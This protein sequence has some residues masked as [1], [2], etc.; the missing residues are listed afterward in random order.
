[1]SSEDLNPE[2]SNYAQACQPETNVVDQSLLEDLRKEQSS[3]T[4][5]FPIC[6]LLIDEALDRFFSN[7]LVPGCE[8]Y[9]DVLNHEPMKL[10]QKVFVPVKQYPELNLSSMFG[11]SLVQ[12]QEAT[13][14]EIQIKGRNSMIDKVKEEEL[15]QSGDPR[16]KHLNKDLFLEISTV[17]TPIECYTRIAYALGEIRKCLIPET[18]DD[19]SHEELS[20]IIKIEP[21]V[22]GTQQI[23]KC[24]ELEDSPIMDDLP[25]EVLFKEPKTPPPP[26]L[27]KPQDKPF[28]FGLAD[29]L[30]KLLDETV[31]NPNFQYSEEETMMVSNNIDILNSFIVS[32]VPSNST[33]SSSGA[34]LENKLLSTTAASSKVRSQSKN[35]GVTK[36]HTTK[37]KMN[38]DSNNV[39][40]KTD[41]TRPIKNIMIRNALMK[42]ERSP[43]LFYIKDK[44]ND[45]II[46]RL[47]SNRTTLSRCLKRSD[48]ETIEPE[49]EVEYNPLT[50]DSLQQTPT[51]LVFEYTPRDIILS[52]LET[53]KNYRVLWQFH[54]KPFN[55]DYIEA[56]EDLCQI[57]NVKWSLNIDSLKMR[58]SINRV[59][60]FYRFVFPYENIEKFSEYFDKCA[61]FLPSTV[62]EIPH[63]RCSHCFICF[64]ED[65]ELRRH[66]VEEHK[67]LKWPHKCQ[68][69]AESYEDN[70]EYEFHKRLPHYVEIFT[71][72]QCNE[73]L[74]HRSEYN[75]HLAKHQQKQI[76]EPRNHVCNECGKK[77]RTNGELRS[78][79]YYHEEK[80]FKCHLCP[81]S[82]FKSPTLTIHLKKHRNQLDYICE[83]CGKGFL[84]QKY[85]N[86]HMDT[87]N[88]IQIACNICNLKLRRGNLYRHLRTCHVAVEGTI[89]STF[90]AKGHR[91]NQL[92]H[93][94]RRTHKINPIYQPSKRSKRS[95]E[96]VPR[97]YDC[98]VCNIHFDRLKFLKDHNRE[99]HGNIN[100]VSCKMCDS[101][102]A[103]KTN[104]KRHYREKHKL[105]DY[106]AF[107]LVDK[108]E[109]INKV[110]S[111]TKEE[112]N[113]QSGN[114]SD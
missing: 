97:Q 64:K 88:G 56:I 72:E 14:C 46:K 98:K 91:H 50:I 19:V 40:S 77:F 42:R 43:G 95:E 114:Q 53:M 81:K 17:S 39:E 11:S 59:L 25:L 65:V 55:E 7:G 71:C 105:S 108:D 100:K 32:K 111:M 47:I 45:K 102:L 24:E 9:A 76:E 112:M 73:K 34:N 78:H 49:E 12:L 18:N 62:M 68:H 61:A 80:K 35:L 85:L 113:E 107:E 13:Q 82:Y 67:S 51:E 79:K 15:R 110:L 23:V 86:E 60:R 8:C 52:L 89:E 4:D 27:D 94:Q 70:D 54:D 106:Q 58:R 33:P 21:E 63:A 6:A 87:H 28:I 44:K 57:V 1:M 101:Q 66:L 2:S 69:C 29:K 3:L 83:V 20:E 48:K 37:R 109:D 96:K 36:K 92:T 26:L 5:N 31:L 75:Q 10:T 93:P 22:V 84:Q 41:K 38:R 16:F 90:R 104:L 30:I 74:N 99:N 103:Q